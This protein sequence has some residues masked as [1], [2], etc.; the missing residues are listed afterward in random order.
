MA[1]SGPVRT[2][3]RGRP[4]LVTV[5]QLREAILAIR[6]REPTMDDLAER[7]GVS[8]ATLYTHV[9]GQEALRE[10]ACDTVLE[11][12]ELSEAAP[13]V[14]WAVWARQYAW[15]LRNKFD[16]YPVLLHGLRPQAGGQMNHVEQVIA[17]FV[18]L[19]LDVGTAFYTYYALMSLTVGTGISSAVARFEPESATRMLAE[20]LRSTPGEV[21]HLRTILEGPVFQL[22]DSVFD[23]L[24]CFTLT[25]IASRRGEAL[26]ELQRD[27][28]ALGTDTPKPG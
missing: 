5:E 19:G 17:R 23:D 25:G 2:R 20:A 18:D 4:P 21:P 26:P 27:Q 28:P 15:E 6:G 11:K 9:R 14:H 7:L 24:V 1:E 22:V 10:L 16:E 12:W 13:G 8:R 3:E